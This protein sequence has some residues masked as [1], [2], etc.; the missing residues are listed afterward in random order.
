MRDRNSAIPT[1]LAVLK[2][3]FHA[4][5]IKYRHIANALGSSEITIKRYMNG[6]GLT[7]DVLERLS[8]VLGISIYD[9]MDTARNECPLSAVKS[10]KK[11]RGKYA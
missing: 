3:E 11:I 1:I 2:R 6:R 9:L 5:D 7:V 4:R 10:F 8:A